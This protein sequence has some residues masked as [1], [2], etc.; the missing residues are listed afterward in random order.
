MQIISCSALILN[1]SRDQVL[2]S[3]R[4]EDRRV[5]P[6]LWEVI[7]GRLEF[8]EEPAACLLREVSEELSVAVI[9][10]QLL[11]VY[12]CLSEVGGNPVHLISLVYTCSIA[13][14]PMANPQEIAELRWVRPEDLNSLRFAANCRE[15][16]EDYFR[17]QG[18][19]TA[20]ESPRP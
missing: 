12:S 14:E 3:R 19:P 17:R 10:P 16:V 11:G 2:I 1:E 6:G 20:A 18:W 5:A 9:D 15:R 13:G 8:G 7:G 4:S